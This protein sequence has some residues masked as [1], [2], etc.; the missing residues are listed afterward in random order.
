MTRILITGCTGFIGRFLSKKLVERGYEVYGLT[1]RD[2]FFSKELPIHYVYGDLKDE[3]SLEKALL[4]ARP[5]IILHLAALTPV[6]FSFNKPREYAEV[7]YI[8]TVNL[9][10]AVVRKKVKLKQFV[11]ASTSEVYKSKDGL[12]SEGDPLFGGTPYGISK[13]AADFYIQSAGL[14][15][16]LP[17]TIL[18]PANTFGRPFNLPEEAK[19]YLIEKC[20]IQ[21]L[22]Q[23]KAYF[24]G[25]PHPK[26]CFLYVED[27]T[28]AYLSILEKEK[29]IQ[30]VFNV[31]PNNPTSVGEVVSLIGKLTGFQGE[32]VWG[33]KPRPYDPPSIC[34]SG[35]KIMRKIGWKAKYTLE[36]GLKKTIAYWRGILKLNPRNYP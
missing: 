20:I 27:H 16:D 17:Y 1:R 3:K 22:T 35:N 5:D 21:M 33:V 6:R 10:Q 8:G 11:H 14:A 4:K 2:K 9:V 18:R 28:N 15:F 13:A 23:K 29:A 36:E 19:G 31:S 26:R 25:H 30:E 7:N 34:P 24:D 32:I 12:I